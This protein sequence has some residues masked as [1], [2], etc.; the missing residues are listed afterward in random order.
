[1]WCKTGRWSTLQTAVFLAT[2]SVGGAKSAT[3]ATIGVA[4]AHALLAP[5]VALGG[6]IWV[7]APMVILQKSREKWEEATR[8]MT[9]LFWAWAP[10]AI[11][12][13]AIENWS[14]LCRN[15]KEQKEGVL[16][17]DSNKSS[18]INPNDN[19]LPTEED[20]NCNKSNLN[21]KDETKEIDHSESKMVTQELKGA[22]LN[23]RKDSMEDV[24]LYSKSTSMEDVDLLNEGDEPEEEKKGDDGEKVGGAVVRGV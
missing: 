19:K 2:N 14:G 11:F 12:V 8:K 9:D 5:V 1:V 13:A 17:D 16:K 15:D 21:V 23:D 4:A 10:P 18:N 20:S 6:V 3:L 22:T 24:S 7:T